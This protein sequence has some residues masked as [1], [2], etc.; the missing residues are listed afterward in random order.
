MPLPPEV[1][2]GLY[3]SG[4]VRNFQCYS[5]TKLPPPVGI[6]G[7]NVKLWETRVNCNFMAPAPP[8][9][10]RRPGYFLTDT[11]PRNTVFVDNI[12]NGVAIGL[13]PPSPNAT[14]SFSDQ[15]GGC[16]W[17][18]LTNGGAPPTAAF[19]HVYRGGGIVTP[20]N[21]GQGW[22]HIHTLKSAHLAKAYGVSGSNWAYAYRGPGS[23]IVECCMLHLNN[24]GMVT[25]RTHHASVHL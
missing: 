3:I 10:A 8:D 23:N 5:T 19:L 11:N 16:E 7:N 6:T 21:L 4:N 20:Y 24:H 14:Y 18:L 2:T 13:A 9:I 12:T 17:H 22:M 1:A 15:Y 25:A